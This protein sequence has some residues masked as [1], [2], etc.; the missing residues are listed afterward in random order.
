MKTIKS[1]TPEDQGYVKRDIQALRA[2]GHAWR[3]I[4]DHLRVGYGLSISDKAMRRIA[5]EA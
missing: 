4:K 1:L 5:S 3:K 2:E